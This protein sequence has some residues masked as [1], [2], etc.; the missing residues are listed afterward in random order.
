MNDKTLQ[1]LCYFLP[2]TT[3]DISCSSTSDETREGNSFNHVAHM[4]A[5]VL[6]YYTDFAVSDEYKYEWRHNYE[7]RPRCRIPLP[8]PGFTDILS[9]LKSASK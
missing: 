3:F 6:I 5:L 2:Q 9:M 4:Q 7:C 1:A 8:T